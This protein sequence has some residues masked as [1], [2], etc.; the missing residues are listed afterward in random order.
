[1]SWQHPESQKHREA[2]EE[3]R[4][5]RGQSEADRH[6]RRRRNQGQGEGDPGRSS[7]PQPPVVE[8]QKDERSYRP[9]EEGD[10]ADGARREKFVLRPADLRHFEQPLGRLVRQRSDGILRRA[11]LR[12]SCPAGRGGHRLRCWERRRVRDAHHDIPF[13]DL[14]QA[15]ARR[16]AALPPREFVSYQQLLATGTGEAD[17]HVPL[18]LSLLA[19]APS[20]QGE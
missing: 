18:S 9:G 14:Q 3:T 12:R 11:S 8:D 7:F 15:A 6:H 13:G 16:A 1:M 19:S 20:F 4:N 2:N 5:G 17:G 10:Q